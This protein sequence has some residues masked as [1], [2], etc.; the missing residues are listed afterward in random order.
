MKTI[1]INW[2]IINYKNYQNIYYFYLAI[3]KQLVYIYLFIA[4]R[5]IVGL[6]LLSESCYQ[7][8]Q[9]QQQQ[10]ST[11]KKFQCSECNIEPCSF[12]TLK[13]LYGHAHSLTNH[14]THPHHPE[15]IA[16]QYRTAINALHC[17]AQCRICGSPFSTKGNCTTHE[18]QT[19]YCREKIKEMEQH[20]QSNPTLTAAP[21]AN[22]QLPDYDCYTL[23]R[24]CSNTDKLALD[25]AYNQ[26][27]DDFIRS[28]IETPSHIDRF[29]G[30]FKLKES[31]PNKHTVFLEEDEQIKI[32]KLRSAVSR[33]FA[34]QATGKAF[35]RLE[36]HYDNVPRVLIT[37][38]EALEEFK[39]KHPDSKNL[40][41]PPLPAG[42][43]MQGQMDP[44]TEDE[45]KTIIL[46]IK[47]AKSPGEDG[48]T[49]QHLKYLV[50]QHEPFLKI[51]EFFFNQLLNNPRHLQDCKKLF[52]F[53]ALL[54]PKKTGGFR[55]VSCESMILAVFSS[56][57]KT[58]LM[59]QIKI[60]DHQFCFKSGGITHAL[61]RVESFKAKGKTLTL[62][63]C[64]NAYQA[65]DQNALIHS[66]Q[67]NG[68][69]SL[70]VE[71]YRTYLDTRSCKYADKIT[72]GCPAGSS[73]SS[74]AFAG[75]LTDVITA[76]EAKGYQLTVFA[77]DIQI[78]HDQN[79]DKDVVLQELAA[80]LQPLGLE[81]ALNKCSSTQDGGEITF[82]G[83]TFSQSSTGSLAERMTAKIDKCL[84]VLD[85]SPITNHQKFL[86][87]RSVVLPKVNYAPLVDFAPK[88]P[89]DGFGNQ[90]GL[91]DQKVFKYASDLFAVKDLSE[92]EQADFFTNSASKGGLEMV[93][94]SLYY[95]F[96][97]A[98]QKAVLAGKCGV[99]KALRKEYLNTLQDHPGVPAIGYAIN[100]FTYLTDNELFDL[101]KHRF[102]VLN[103]ELDSE[104]KCL[105]C[106][107]KMT[108][109]HE[110]RCNRN[111]GIRTVRHDYMVNRILTKI[112]HH[113]HPR[114]VDKAHGNLPS[115]DKLEKPD[116][117]FQYK[118]ATYVLD[119]TFAVEANICNAF[120]GHV[121]R[122]SGDST[123]SSL[124]RHCVR[125]IH[126]HANNIP[127]RD[128][129]LL[130]KQTLLPCSGARQRRSQAALHQ[131]D[132]QCSA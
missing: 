89:Q 33:D 78:S 42:I 111:A 72:S 84:K 53:R 28:K 61:A 102:Q 125:E 100:N 104:S 107:K 27:H 115:S 129:G 120:K 109:Q 8:Q 31:K 35:Q 38:Q 48:I 9:Q 64:T 85:A 118:N 98:Q 26:L 71:Y 112:D 67:L 56:C 18:K 86:L 113:R 114:P 43:V 68:V 62:A 69:N 126:E 65:I 54:I 41:S 57:L 37:E 46:R 88:I 97:Q 127:A 132:H 49:G 11:A 52:R 70:F 30:Q 36:D 32:R 50:Y 45:I 20:A 99:F 19:P 105:L 92:T 2:N 108:A 39:R 3:V 103:K 13:G 117:E 83:Q 87:L 6:L 131:L 59:Q 25:K 5:C 96:M 124:Q 15:K 47:K 10:Y 58:R 63:D 121:W 66:L 82:L 116:I 44:I 7:K 94:P 4:F 24:F 130:P 12:P 21:P 51:L 76:M 34:L 60:H 106:G 23:S 91:I 14:P 119:V 122:Q 40:Q 55:P 90:Y 22:V 93:V 73:T 74:M 1:L 16:E 77:D 110:I 80:L 95:D 123:R 101:I 75:A 81:L 79:V 128:H 29:I 17:K